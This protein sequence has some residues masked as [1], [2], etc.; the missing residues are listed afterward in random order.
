MGTLE[1]VSHT[2][3]LNAIKS[4]V[5]SNGVEV[6]NGDALMSDDISSDE[7]SEE[8]ETSDGTAGEEVPV[9]TPGDETAGD[10]EEPAADDEGH[11]PFVEKSFVEAEVGATFKDGEGKIFEKLEGVDLPVPRCNPASEMYKNL[12]EYGFDQDVI[13]REFWQG[14]GEVSEDTIKALKE[15]FPGGMV[16]E[17]FASKKAEHL[18][19]LDGLSRKNSDAE[20]AK[21]AVAEKQAKR[22]EETLSLVA[23]TFGAE[24]G[25]AQWAEVVDFINGNYE[26]D[27]R[28]EIAAA[29]AGGTVF[30]RKA[31]LNSIKRDM[32]YATGDVHKL[33]NSDGVVSVA[34]VGGGALTGD[35]YHKI[36]SNPSHPDHKRYHTEPSYAAEVDAR[37]QKGIE[38]G[39]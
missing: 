13:N 14:K 16:D 26:V 4:Q 28:K 10:G 12:K 32:E 25:K 15:V 24:D 3:D 36:L 23:T 1:S 39:L 5:A 20:K 6:I 22:D 8:I 29:L 31:L 11:L 17:F 37:R 27:R 33:I 18:A 7:S 30:S 9:E 35:A 34:K 21:V 2:A 38:L 19:F